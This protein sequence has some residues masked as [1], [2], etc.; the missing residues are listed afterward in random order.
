M[1]SFHTSIKVPLFQES[2]WWSGTN[3]LVSLCVY[4]QEIDWTEYEAKGAKRRGAAVQFLGQLAPAYS[5][6]GTEIRSRGLIYKLTYDNHTIT[7]Q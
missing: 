1:S 7:L 2:F 3:L 5:P 6:A 4:L